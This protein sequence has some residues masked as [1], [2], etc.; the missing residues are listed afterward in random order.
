VE[1]TIIDHG[2]SVDPRHRVDIHSKETFM[3]RTL[4]YK[5]IDLNSHDDAS[6]AHLEDILNRQAEDGWA[7]VTSF[8]HT[9][10][11]LQVGSTM[12][13][14]PGLVS[15]VLVFKRDDE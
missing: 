3:V 10:T 8:Q 4:C 11:A 9:H 7:L 6:P 1:D 12:A 15:T 14:V 2:P 13:P 5:V